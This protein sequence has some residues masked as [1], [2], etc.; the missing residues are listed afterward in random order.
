MKKILFLLIGTLLFVTPVFSQT[1]TYVQTISV[2]AETTSPTSIAFYDGDLFIATF[3]ERTIIKVDD[4]TDGGATVS[5]L[6]D[7]SGLA[8]WAGGR[9][10]SGIDVNQSTGDIY[11]SGDYGS[12]TAIARVNQAGTQTASL[13]DVLNRCG[14]CTLWGADPDVLITNILTGLG[15]MDAGLVGYE[16]FTASSTYPRDVAVVGNDIYASYTN[17]GTNDGILKFTGGTAGDLTGYTSSNWVAL[18]A[19]TWQAGCGVAYWD[20]N[21]GTPMDYVMFANLVNN[22]LEI[23]D[24]A[25]A[26][27]DITLGAVENVTTPRDACIGTIG[28]NDF[29]FVCEGTNAEVDVFA[30]DGATDVNSWSLY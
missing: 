9:G 11:A 4:P 21:G 13:V 20:Y 10:L 24:A 6:I 30:I 18:G 14:G 22:T 2:A 1:L 16:T 12:G 28:G 3:T 23:Y 29:L 15:E 8:A 25:D 27:L 17:G 5:T 26:S 19:G 7:L